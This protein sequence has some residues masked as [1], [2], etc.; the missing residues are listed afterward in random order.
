MA[1]IK[2]GILWSNQFELLSASNIKFPSGWITSYG[3]HFR[4][5]LTTH[6]NNENKTSWRGEY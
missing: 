2:V 4:E 3:F 5:N 6:K 1:E